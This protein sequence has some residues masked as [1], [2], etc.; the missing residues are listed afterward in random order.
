MSP[1]TVD[2]FPIAALEFT[3][4]KNRLP[5]LLH[6]VS[7]TYRKSGLFDTGREYLMAQSVYTSKIIAICVYKL[8]CFRFRRNAGFYLKASAKH[9]ITT[10]I[11]AILRDVRSL[12]KGK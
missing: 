9:S 1:V 6:L 7:Q 3:Y 4:T 8:K 10:S 5:K 11:A 12:I 2:T